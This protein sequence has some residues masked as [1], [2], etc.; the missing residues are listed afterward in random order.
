MAGT[1]RAEPAARAE[2]PAADEDKV[3]AGAGRWAAKLGVAAVAVVVT[4]VVLN[5]AFLLGGYLSGHQRMYMFDSLL[6][7]RVRPNLEAARVPYI[8]Y[9][10]MHGFRILPNE[11]RDTQSFDVMLVGDSF[12]FGSWYSAEDSVAGLFKLAHPRLRIANTA[13]PGYGTDQ[14]LLAL[15]RYA[16]LLKQGGLVILLT[17]VNDFDDIRD[18]WEEV[19]EKPWFTM[20]GGQLVLQTPDS[21]VNRFFWSA[22]IFSVSAYLTSLAIGIQPA[23]YGDDAYAATLYTALV[24][25]M[26]AVVRARGGRFVVLYAGGRET[27]TP[28]GRR[29]TAVARSGAA[30]VG[31]AFFALDDRNQVDRSMYAPDKIHWN[32]QGNHA[33]YNFIAPR[34]EPLLQPDSAQPSG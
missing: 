23:I 33:I 20:D 22:H 15:Q 27:N 6:G 14:E 34:L 10:D 32:A 11:P 13:V 5:Y 30:Q 21:L 25:R 3:Q 18:R 8:T 24:Q 19:R 16:P 1:Q 28:P 31:A 12:C 29:W 2:P 7:W 4:L 26:A 9:T 17:Y